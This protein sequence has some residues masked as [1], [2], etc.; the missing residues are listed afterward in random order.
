MEKRIQ[1]GLVGDFSEKIHTHIALNDAIEHCKPHLGFRLEATWIPTNAING[2]FLAQ[3]RYNGFWIAPGSPYANDD[4]VFE[5][6]RY[7]RENDFPLL[8]TC[9]GF[10]YM[11]VEYAKNVLGFSD[12]GH[13][14]S[15]PDA[16]QLIISKLAC[17][18]KGQQ[19]KITITDRHSWLFD[20]L[21]KDSFTGSFYCGYGVNSAFTRL[22]DQYP[23]VFT[24]FSPDNEPRAFELKAHRF[25]AGTLFQ[26]PLDSSPE[27]PNSLLISFF[28]KC[29]H[30]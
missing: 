8:G 1:I 28:K 13:E 24:A 26:P 20:V 16:K 21:K 12:A 17:S 30:D 19:E 10:Q 14:E 5:L 9:G 22:I 4:G 3:H 18:L 29:A 27:N 23:F 7:A 2:N 11:V 25:F 15:Q 6:I